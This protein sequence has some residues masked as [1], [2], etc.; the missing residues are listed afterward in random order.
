MGG[1]ALLNGTLHQCSDLFHD[2]G[3]G[4][5]IFRST[6]IDDRGPS[7]AF[8]CIVCNLE[9]DGENIPPF[10]QTPLSI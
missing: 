3:S 1:K 9:T 4:F 6:K 10:K 8:I 5:D 2:Y 7:G